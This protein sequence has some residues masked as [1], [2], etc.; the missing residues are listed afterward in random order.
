MKKTTK[1][2]KSRKWFI[3]VRGSYLPNSAA[4]WLTYIPY[5][6]YLLG[7]LIFVL[8]HGYGLGVGILILVP[9]WIAAVAVMNWIAVRN[10]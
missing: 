2:V 5:V 3:Q 6:G 7:S 1:K 8:K 9:N 10:S 4:G